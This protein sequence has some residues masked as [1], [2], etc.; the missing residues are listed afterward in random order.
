MKEPEIKSCWPF[1]AINLK[2]ILEESLRTV[3]V[4]S[5]GHFFDI[6]NI[7]CGVGEF[8]MK[9]LNRMK[10]SEQFDA[11]QIRSILRAARCH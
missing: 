10:C 11:G 4:S 3:F 6:N 1:F 2:R 8:L 9:M 7:S 5:H